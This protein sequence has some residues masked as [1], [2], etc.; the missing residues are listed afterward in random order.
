MYHVAYHCGTVH[1]HKRAC[2]M[3]CEYINKGFLHTSLFE[4]WMI[5]S[6]HQ[7]LD[8]PDSRNQ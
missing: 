3:Q 5:F 7:S 4:L 2:G 8:W 1:V 6:L